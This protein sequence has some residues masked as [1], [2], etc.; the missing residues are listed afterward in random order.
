MF[1]GGVE[2]EE[3]ETDFYQQFKNCPQALMYAYHVKI[4]QA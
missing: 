4:L 2:T 3:M 1:S